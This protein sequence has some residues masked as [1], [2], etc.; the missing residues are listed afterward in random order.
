VT[1][2]FPS[3]RRS[4]L[5]SIAA[6]TG[7]LAPSRAEVARASASAVGP[8]FARRHT[9]LEIR[10]QA[11][12]FQA[13]QPAATSFGNGDETN[14]PGYVASFTKGLPHD[15]AGNVD[16]T[17]YQSLLKALHTG[18]HGD[19]EKIR[20]GSGMKLLDPQ[21][22]FAYDLVGQDS[23]C[24]HCAPAPAFS[25]AEAAAEM[26]ELYW[27]SLARDVPFS[28]YETS[29]VIRNA[30]EDLS[31]LSD[32][33]GPKNAGMVPASHV[34]R[35]DAPGCLPGPYISQFLWKRIP[36]NSTWIEQ[37]YR[38]PS[39]GI[40]YLTSMP[41]WLIL[42][43][44]LPPFRNPSFEAAPKYLSSGRA[45][46]EWVHYDFLYQAFHNAALILLNQAP[47]TILDTN[48]CW[49]PSNPYKNSKVQTGFATFGAPHVCAWLG[50]VTTSALQAS[51][52][53]KWRVHRRLRPEE[54][55]GRV[56]QTMTKAATYKFADELS[57][58]E[59]LART[60]AAHG[61][62]LLPQSYPEGCP[63]HPAYPAGH[64]TVAGACSA[65]LKAFFDETAL[66]T[67]CVAASADGHTLE[68][69]NGALTIGGELNKLAANICMGRNFA[70]I[71]YRSDATAGLR[72]GEEVAVAMLQDLV[73]TL[74]EDFPGFSFARLD[75]TPVFIAR[76]GV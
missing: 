40:D 52:Y 60:F 14:L 20:R 33:R 76:R 54:F 4:F 16:S 25:S 47:E 26:V 53:Q 49:S 37:K 43:S 50:Q 27:H 32:F 75:G 19:F 67:N 21:A 35:C 42:Q 24:F 17:A 59:G 3:G 28:Q 29:P 39:P 5:K 46:A 65:L 6:L 31:R 55:G 2:M 41:E 1:N 73:N 9:A 34:F 23:N 38:A 13:R 72:L 18:A 64:A 44:G 8:M 30:A 11:A 15:Q 63:L 22:A 69:Y 12:E 61:A 58:S 62:Y 51:W 68:P 56:H 74:T 48:S 7:S 10:R 70:G 71:H 36:L 57:R 66:L 45:L